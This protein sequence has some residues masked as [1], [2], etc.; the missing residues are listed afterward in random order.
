[1]HDL[2]EAHCTTVHV[3]GDF[4]MPDG[5][6]SASGE[7]STKS[8]ISSTR[9]LDLREYAIWLELRRKSLGGSP[10]SLLFRIWAIFRYLFVPGFWEV[11][12]FLGL[13][14]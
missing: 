14:P 4:K 3:Q 10:D 7:R 5:L 12:D 1:M 6:D 8:G 9:T 13:P 2:R 11:G